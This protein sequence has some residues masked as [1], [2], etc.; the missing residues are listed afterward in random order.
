MLDKLKLL[1][2]ISNDAYDDEITDLIESVQSDLLLHGIKFDLVADLTDGLICRCV[3]LY[4]K[5]N[6]GWDNLDRE[7]LLKSYYMLRDHLSYS[8]DYVEEVEEG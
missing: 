3:S 2:R 7:G 4:V 1:L 8:V 5:A 6:F